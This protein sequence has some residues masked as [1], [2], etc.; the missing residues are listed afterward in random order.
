MSF[1]IG[2]DPELFL[3]RNGKPYSAHGVIPGT[4]KEPH[5]VDNGAIQVDGM[6]V[7]FNID[8]TNLNSH[9]GFKSF[10]HK[11]VSVI[12]QMK[13]EVKKHDPALT[14]NIESV[15]QFDDETMAAAPEEAKELGCDPDFN[16]YTKEQNP[17]PKGDV[18][19]RTA[20]GHIHLGWGSDIPVEHPD[21]VTICAD[22]IKIMD[23]FVGLYMTIIDPES[24]RRDLYGKAGAFRPKPYGVEYRT[25]SNLWLTNKNRRKAIFELTQLTVRA[26]QNQYSLARLLNVTKGEEGAKSW[27]NEESERMLQEIINTGDF[28][29]A[30]A[31]L[32]RALSI[33][34]MAGGPLKLNIDAEYT[35]RLTSKD[36]VQVTN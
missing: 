5:K 2:A 32:D 4:K 28:T 31:N 35:A 19:F 27:D 21:H 24:R 26:A 33:F 25:P 17:R 9:D 12:K 36:N 7:E 15:Q 6:A 34:W 3:R 10:N 14:F 29:A 1:T 13:E 16:A 18:P 8:P 20:A 22:F 11:V 23:V 30:K